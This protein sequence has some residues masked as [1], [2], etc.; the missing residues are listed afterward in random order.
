MSHKGAVW[1]RKQWEDDQNW[2]YDIEFQLLTFLASQW[3]NLPT[4]LVDDASA[5][6]VLCEMSRLK[7]TI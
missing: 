3:K 5:A 2:T 1:R 4:V 7:K 6:H